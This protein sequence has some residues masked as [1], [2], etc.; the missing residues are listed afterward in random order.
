[1]NMIQVSDALRNAGA[2]EGENYAILSAIIA[3]GEADDATKVKY[4]TM[5]S[6]ICYRLV[7]GHGPEGVMS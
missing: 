6:D 3:M 2:T 7:E 4:G 1:M 5:A